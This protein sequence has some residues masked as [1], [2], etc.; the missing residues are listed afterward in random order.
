MLYQNNVQTTICPKYQGCTN[1]KNI[2]CNTCSPHNGVNEQAVE[3]FAKH[4]EKLG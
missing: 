3:I 1:I 4:T 2:Y